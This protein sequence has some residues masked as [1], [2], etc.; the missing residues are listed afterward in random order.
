MGGNTESLPQHSLLVWKCRMMA[1]CTGETDR[2]RVRSASSTSKLTRPRWYF[3]FRVLMAWKREKQPL[4]AD[5]LMGTMKHCVIANV[6]LP[7]G[8]AALHTPLPD[9]KAA[10]LLMSQPALPPPS[11]PLP[12]HGKHPPQH[13][14][15]FS[16]CPRPIP[17]KSLSSLVG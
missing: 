9:M 4:A 1:A 17:K 3:Q 10:P 12:P 13:K 8:P 16:P 11:H 15:L 14:L 6:P 2:E 7:P 5:L